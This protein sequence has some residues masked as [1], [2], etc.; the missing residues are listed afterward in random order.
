MNCIGSMSVEGIS[1]ASLCPIFAKKL[2]SE[3]AM[4]PSPVI[5]CMLSKFDIVNHVCFGR[6]AIKQFAYVAPAFFRIFTIPNVGFEVLSFCVVDE[7]SNLV[8]TLF[9]RI[10]KGRRVQQDCIFLKVISVKTQ[11]FNIIGHRWCSVTSHFSRPYRYVY[12]YVGY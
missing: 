10:A 11:F 2:L 9:K 1:E 12:I 8:S 6:F 5:F 3:F 4:L 7:F